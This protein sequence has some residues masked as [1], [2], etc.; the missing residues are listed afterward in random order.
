[1]II[2]FNNHWV[3]ICSIWKFFTSLHNSICLCSYLIPFHAKLS[4]AQ[5]LELCLEK[6]LIFKPYLQQCT[7]SFKYIFLKQSWWKILFGS[8]R[9]CIC[10]TASLLVS[11]CSCKIN[12]ISSQ[13]MPAH[14][15]LFIFHSLFVPFLFQ[16]F[17]VKF[18]KTHIRICG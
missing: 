10:F 13:D 1:M 9:H 18:V 16:E 5:C 8:Q 11:Q 3:E 4:H 12:K 7:V 6:I 14:I 15:K 17:S 2:I